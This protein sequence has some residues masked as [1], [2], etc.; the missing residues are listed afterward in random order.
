MDGGVQPVDGRKE[1]EQ[2]TARGLLVVL[3]GLAGGGLLGSLLASWVIPTFG[4]QS[5]FYIGAVAPLV[6]AV[7][8]SVGKTSAK[9]AIYAVVSGKFETRKNIKN[10]N[11][12]FGL[13]FTIIGVDS[14]KSNPVKWLM[15]FMKSFWMVYGYSH[16]P[17]V[18][19]LELGIDRPGDMDALMDII[20]PDIA[21]LTTI[22]ISHLEYFSS[23]QQ[24]F[25]EKSRIFRDLGPKDFAVLNI[26]D[27]KVRQAIP[28]LHSRI[29]GYGSE[30]TAEV[31]I[32][33]YKTSYSNNNKTFGTLMH[34]NYKGSVVPV[35][36]NNIL[37]LPH[38]SASAAGVAV[39]IAMGMQ[40]T[41]ISEGLLR[42]QPEPGRM[43]PIPGIHGSTIID[44]TYNAAPLSMKVAIEELVHFPAAHKIAVL[45]DMLELGE[46]SDKAHKDV[47]AQIMNSSIDYFV[48]VGPQMKLAYSELKRSMFKE[49]HL[50]W[51]EKS[52]DAFEKV[53]SIVRDNTVVLV[54][55]S[56]GMHMENIVKE[57]SA[58]K[59]NS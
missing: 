38:V 10:Y 57:I 29:I 33:D 27:S 35:F 17:K 5:L 51:F 19:V 9:E 20:K 26:D 48:A 52:S 6:I 40:L 50:F 24:I 22:G 53:Q 30:P 47:A 11:N 56:R 28:K 13:P 25:E 4:W 3:V 58:T 2:P 39:G 55:G 59:K 7:T 43:R 31:R 42:Y 34:L 44:D 16:Y 18:L 37:G 46:L 41:E 15:L 49:D 54:K 36:L 23:E 45:G 32:V 8:G 21:V 14:P 1:L 12:E